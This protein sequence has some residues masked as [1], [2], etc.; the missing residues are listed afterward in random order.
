[1][2]ETNGVGTAFVRTPNPM[3]LGDFFTF[4][5][6]LNDGREPL[7][8]QGKVI[9]TNQ[10]GQDKKHLRRGMGVKFVKLQK[11]EQKRIGDY[12]QEGG[13]PWKELSRPT[14]GKSFREQMVFTGNPGVLKF[15]RSICPPSFLPE[16]REDWFP[17]IENP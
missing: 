8:L 10:Y 11:E 7:M 17:Q 15:I 2:G 14:S 16:A 3:E 5:L 12:T 1:M 13:P 6:F 4:K 9:W